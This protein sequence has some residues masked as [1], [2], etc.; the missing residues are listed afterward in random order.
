[1]GKAD[2]SHNNNM[3]KY[4]SAFRDKLQKYFDNPPYTPTKNS[5]TRGDNVSY[6]GRPMKKFVWFPES[7]GPEIGVSASAVRRWLR[8]VSLPSLSNMKAVISTIFGPN[9]EQ[10]TEEIEGFWESLRY[11]ERVY[12]GDTEGVLTETGTGDGSSLRGNTSTKKLEL[13]P[14][15]QNLSEAGDQTSLPQSALNAEI[16]KLSV[17]EKAALFAIAATSTPLDEN[18]LR[19]LLGL[20]G[21]NCA[22][23]LTKK[24]LVQRNGSLLTP[25]GAVTTLR[26]ALCQSLADDFQV[27]VPDM[28]AKVPLLDTREPEDA[29]QRRLES[30]VYRLV[31]I[32][33]ARGMS[34]SEIARR[35]E[36]MLKTARQGEYRDTFLAGNLVNLLACDRHRLSGM[37][38]SG[39]HIKHAFLRH[40][41]LRGTDLSNAHLEYCVLADIFGSIWQVGFRDD[42]REVLASS[43]S[44]IV[45]TWSVVTAGSIET[46][47]GRQDAHF[48]WSF[49][50]AVSADGQELASAGGDG[51]I[52]IWRRDGKLVDRLTGHQSRVR[53]LAFRPDGSLISCS[54]DRRVLQWSRRYGEQARPA[55]LYRHRDRTTTLALSANGRFLISGANG[56]EVVLYDFDN[57]SS[58]HCITPH[59]KEVRVVRFSTDS[60]HAISAGD[61]GK[62]CIWHA[63]S[64]SIVKEIRLN[65]DQPT[66][67]S[68]F[69]GE[70]NEMFAAGTDDGWISIWKPPYEK[71]Y[72]KWQAHASLIRSL[73]SSSD[74]ASL[75]SGG[76]DQTVMVWRFNE[77]HSD[78]ALVRSFSGYSA[79]AR[80]VAFVKRLIATAHDD[81]VVRIWD[82][83]TGKEAPPFL[84]EG[85]RGRIWS[86][87]FFQNDQ[88]LVTGAE[89]GGVRAWRMGNRLPFWTGSEHEYRVFA[90]ATR[91]G[92]TPLIASGGSDSR[93][94]IWSIKQS[95]SLFTL[96]H[97]EGHTRRIRDL[98][99][100]PDGGLLCSVGEDN[101]ILVWQ[102]AD[103]AWRCVARKSETSP[104]TSVRFSPD[105]GH[106]Y[107]GTDAGLVAAWDRDADTI[108]YVS[109]SD[110]PVLS[111]GVTPRGDKLVAGM[112]DGKIAVISSQTLTVLALE[113]AH[114]DWVEQVAVSPDGQ[115]IASVSDDQTVR[116]WHLE[117]LSEKV[118]AMRA[119]AP[120]DGL[121]IDGLTGITEI[122]R[123]RLCAL[124]A[125]EAGGERD[126]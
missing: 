3:P 21:V 1:M 53:A 111:V 100:S 105:G 124:G 34:G 29:L 72:Y 41:E 69:I 4:H 66:K 56:G 118:P 54:E 67:A 85:H 98:A 82:S 112:A 101:Q 103:D 76:D 75:V 126:E 94:K 125:L 70:S 63:D 16:E 68:C 106:I 10:F 51:E 77:E 73:A 93:I 120:Y 19:G 62:I 50:F 97:D 31:A 95:N 18:R 90:V 52:R 99:F 64:H 40:S 42:D 26:E 108:R 47:G 14:V 37:D 78:S 55:E 89:D 61:D 27:R 123:G 33:V 7:F 35:A 39:L 48:G 79:E 45:R 58:R 43:A 36:E 96:G 109:L 71:P 102:E 5:L 57:P 65:Y 59:L 117:Y 24:Y 121:Q 91:D 122:E 25:S 32:L 9:P 49:G 60:T 20:D 116:L 46:Y 110:K 84:I 11:C 13:P 44:G 28:L 113:K 107:W 23:S 12:K 114:D 30:V 6:L 87:A 115:T 8:R 2:K 80:A 74:G 104:V 88:I 81:G 86:L 22:A 92:P 17:N 15:L 38:L 119:R 83:E